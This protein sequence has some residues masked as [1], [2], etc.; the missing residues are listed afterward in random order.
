MDIYIVQKGDT[1]YNIA[2]KFNIT[3]QE[4]MN[5]NNLDNTLLSIGKQL[6]V[7]GNANEMNYYVEK[8]D[9]LESISRKFK[10]NIDL[11]KQLNN[12]NCNDLVEGELLII[13]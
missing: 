5:I 9:T 11:L 8:N 7:P 1:L 13:K 12:L 2:K 6:I 4:L 10:I 3:W